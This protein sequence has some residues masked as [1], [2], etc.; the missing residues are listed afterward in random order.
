MPRSGWVDECKLNG[1]QKADIS[2]IVKVEEAQL[3]ELYH[4]IEAAWK[5]QSCIESDGPLKSVSEL[6]RDLSSAVQSMKDASLFLREQAREGYVVDAYF[7]R[8]N[9]EQP[10]QSYRMQL[11]RK[12]PRSES[13]SDA[14]LNELCAAVEYLAE[15]LP[16]T[17]QN[18]GQ[19]KKHS[20]TDALVIIADAFEANEH[21]NY[22]LSKSVRAPF[23][24]LVEYFINDLVGA[25]GHSAETA[26]KNVLEIR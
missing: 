5:V 26:I 25:V 1:F 15:G 18:Q 14:M 19:S 3:Q 9:Q 2:K 21:I 4:A 20:F 7:F 12:Y 6:K 17:R 24:D 11:R 10:S 22:K 23:R 8:T 13:F 16:E